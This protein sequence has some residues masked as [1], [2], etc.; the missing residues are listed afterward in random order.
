[1]GAIYRQ[2]SLT[3]ATS[4]FFSAIMALTLTPALCATLLK[5]VKAGENLEK[6]GF[7]GWF[8]RAFARTTDRYQGWVARML[9]RTGRY[10][11]IYAAIVG[12][13]GLLYMQLPSS[14]LP[15]DDQGYLL[16]NIQLPAGASGNRTLEV[17][18]QV[19][20]F[21]LNHPAVDKMVAITGFSFT[22]S[23]QNAGVSF[24]KLKDWS[25]RGKDQ[26]ASAIAGQA[27]GA[28]SG[29]RDA[30]VFA[31][32]PPPIPE[33]GTATGFSFRL[34]DR[35]SLGHAALAAANGQLLGMA[36]QSPVLAGVR[37]EG[38]D[39]A[40]QLELKIDRE[41]ASALGVSFADINSVLSTALGSSYVN[42]FPNRGRQQRVVVQAGADQR[43]EADDLLNLHVRNGQGR[44][45]ALSTFARIDWTSGPVQLTRFNGYPAMKI[46]GDAAPGYSTGEAM[47][48]MERLAAGLPEGI[49]YEWTGQSREEKESGAQAPALYAL[50]LLAVFLCLAALYESWSIP[51]AVLLVVPLGIIGSVTGVLLRGMP[52]DI[53][54]KVG[55]IAIVG[56]SAKNAILIIEFAKDLQAQGKSLIEAGVE[57]ARMRFRPIVMTS[58]AFTFGVIP[59]AVSTGAGSASQR[60]LGTAVVGGMITATV[61]AV[62][63][64]PVFFVVIRRLFK[65]SQRQQE[66]EA[67]R[68]APLEEQT[69]A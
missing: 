35:G 5:P 48:E 27:M 7:F 45:V 67:A 26:S 43:T 37:P 8:N 66:L 3:L 56:L 18:K 29:I 60:A 10:M 31:L 36:A 25:E 16:T 14:F 44:M 41:K 61:L 34:Q 50:S 13:L 39:D 21:Y 23:G 33:L 9:R 32:V 40:P 64:V 28:F 53:Y 46:A 52:D 6:K 19:E 59:L 69:D 22:G 68:V 15:T 63:F 17:V 54:F 38:M 55:L 65:G 47:A 51:T 30:I 24:V 49:G 20:D 11:A 4:I 2:F 12:G 62:F 42:D 1:V 58:L 57:A